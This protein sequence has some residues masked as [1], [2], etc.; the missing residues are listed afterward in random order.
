MFPCSDPPPPTPPPLWVPQSST[1]WAP[2][3]GAQPPRLCTKWHA[4]IPQPHAQHHCASLARPRCGCAAL[5][6][7]V[8]LAVVVGEVGLRLCL[9]LTVRG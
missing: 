2:T 7:L 5:R 9:L 1:G 8:L 6:L 3:R 4:S